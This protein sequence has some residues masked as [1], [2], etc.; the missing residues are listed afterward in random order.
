MVRSA[1]L[2][3]GYVAGSAAFFEDYLRRLTT[4]AGGV[5]P[6]PVPGDG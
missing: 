1:A 5:V 6:A 3:E 4:Y 2:V